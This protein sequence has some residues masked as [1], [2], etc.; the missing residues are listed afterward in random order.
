MPLH[1]LG[2]FLL[3]VRKVREKW[4]TDDEDLWFRGE[5]KAYGQSRLRP[6]LYRN[7]AK[8]SAKS[9]LDLLE[10]ET[11][12]FEDFKRCGG[13][14]CDTP[15]E[16]EW[17]WYFLMQ[18]YGGPTRLLDWSDGALMALHF[19][20]R[21]YP[22]A[23]G[24]ALVYIL[25][26]GWLGDL[27]DDGTYYRSVKKN[28]NKF[29]R[30]SDQDKNE[31]DVTYLP[32]DSEDRRKIPLAAAPLLWDPPHVTRRFAAQRSRF[33]IFGNEP[34]WLSRLA[35][36]RESKLCAIA[37]EEIAIPEIK[38]ELRGAGV[39]ESVIF[40]DLDGL[41]REQSQRWEDS[42]RNRKPAAPREPS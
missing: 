6:K 24:D 26:A 29:C 18:H 40:P 25:D 21:D 28:W 5:R 35:D 14:L 11:S 12:F 9:R 27:L 4:N 17:E 16:D 10:N 31:W 37:I 19:A 3:E 8:P 32:H 1:S 2:D 20:I 39:T 38:R 33:M 13:P 30:T 34:N 22:R 23:K 36:K 7:L 41:G 42:R 15:P